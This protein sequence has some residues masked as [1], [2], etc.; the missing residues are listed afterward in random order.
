[1]TPRVEIARAVAGVG[2]AS[3]VG[4]GVGHAVVVNRGVVEHVGVERHFHAARGVAYASAQILAE[5]DAL[6]ERAVDAAACAEGLVARGDGYVHGVCLG[7]VACRRGGDEFYFLDIFGAEVL[8][9]GLHGRGVEFHEDSVD[10]IAHVAFA[11]HRHVA[12]GR[13][14]SRDAVEHLN[15]VEALA[16]R[17]VLHDIYEFAVFL[18]QGGTAPGNHHLVE[19]E[20][21]KGVCGY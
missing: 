6:V 14:H 15:A 7:G 16:V 9:A 10:D 19:V 18:A 1:M 12:V 13:R 8:Q 17:V 21:G 3:G 11:G 5:S 2:C 20:F 4:E